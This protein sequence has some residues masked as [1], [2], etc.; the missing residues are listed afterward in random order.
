MLKALDVGLVFEQDDTCNHYAI[1]YVDLDYVGDLDKR[2]STTSYVFTLAG[3]LKCWKST[4]QST[5]SLSTTEAEYMAL[6]KAVKEAIWL[7]GLM[8]E[9]GVGRSKY[10]FILT[11]R[12][13]FV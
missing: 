7:G 8:D 9:L 4:V 11:V 5:V 12:V 6:T 13:L 2:W 1:G 10:L 3:A